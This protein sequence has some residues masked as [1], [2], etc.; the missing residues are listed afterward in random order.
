LKTLLI[1]GAGSGGTMMANKMAKQLDPAEW[2]IIV[3]DRDER[4]YYQPGFLFIPFNIYTPQDVVKP[5]RD[6]LARGVEMIL[7]DIEL[8]EPA[9]NRVRLVKEKRVI[10]YDVLVI[11]TGCDIDPNETPGLKDGGW[12]QNIFDFYTLEGATALARFLKTW[13]GGRLVVNPAEMPIKCPVAPLE[14]VFLADWFF[15]EHHMRD[16]VELIYVTPLS[17]AFTK[18]R[19][20]AVLGQLLEQKH[21]QVVPDFVISEV[22]NGQQKILSYDGQ[23]VAYDLLVS[24]PVNKG[25]EVIKRSGMGDELNYVPTDMYTLQSKNW[26]NVWVVGDA[27]DVPTS[28]AGSVAHFMHEI[29]VENLLSA[30]AGKEPLAKYDGHANCF[31]ES[32]FEKGFL[33]DFNYDVEPLP[34]MYPLPGIGPF[35]LLGE[36]PIN[37]WGKMMFRWIYW[38]LLLPGA[39]LPFES[40]M[41]MAGKWA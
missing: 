8:I 16:K 7:S 12:H 27:A 34:G 9:A 29:L 21:I 14:F 36:S 32:G 5:K 37:H 33:L 17:G 1:L 30:M 18:P 19:S 23:E 35:S 41:S 13:K 20:S 11:A 40:R 39:E 24:I 26:P 6:F 4:H 10:A 15:H 25:A 3:V 38:N 28:K 2:K 22:D 31:I